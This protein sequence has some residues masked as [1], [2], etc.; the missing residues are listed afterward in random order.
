MDGVGQDERA[1]PRCHFGA[2]HRL[3][4]A[5]LAEHGCHIDATG[6]TDDTENWLGK[7]RTDDARI[8]PLKLFLILLT[9]AVMQHVLITQVRVAPQHYYFF[10]NSL[11]QSNC[12]EDV[13]I[14]MIQLK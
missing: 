5:Q 10:Y 12:M 9:T 11:H 13:Q 6:K 4:E 8:S 1:R 7:V 14:V 3:A 2:N